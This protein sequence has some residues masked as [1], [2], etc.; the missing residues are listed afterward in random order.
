M[1]AA[2]WSRMRLIGWR[3]FRLLLVVG[4]GLIAAIVGL[5]FPPPVTPIAGPAEV[6]DGDTLRIG[7]TRIRLT[8]IDAPELAQTCTDQS[9]REWPCGAEAKA[10][11]IGLVMH[12]EVSCA[13]R[14][15]DR[16]GRSLGACTASGTDIGA[17]I[18]A[19]GWAVSDGGYFTEQ[20]NARNAARGIW[21]GSF[22][23]PAEWRR[24]HGE[25]GNAWGWLASLWR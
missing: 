22:I 17:R 5:A 13:L 8:G 20:E 7:A 14:G 19:A 18:V 24:S 16:Y 11:V 21:S 4:A 2:P 25:G 23:A 9:G 10:F 12:E 15:T 3:R 1:P 6:T